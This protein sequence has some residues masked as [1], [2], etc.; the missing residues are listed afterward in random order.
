MPYAFARKFVRR[1][2]R[3]GNCCEV[4]GLSECQFLPRTFQSPI[5]N[6]HSSPQSPIPSPQSLL[7]Y[8]S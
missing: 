2:S 3:S 4:G 1:S 7:R 6:P 5:P 8:F